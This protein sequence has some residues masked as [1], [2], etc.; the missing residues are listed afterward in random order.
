MSKN[1]T[2]IIHGLLNDK[3]E[4]DASVQC[5]M[6]KYMIDSFACNIYSATLKK[7]YYD[8]I[9]D[10]YKLGKEA[11]PDFIQVEVDKTLR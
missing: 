8:G 1:A 9:P 4:A 2:I 5:G 7:N 11:C 3:I 6:C 10:K